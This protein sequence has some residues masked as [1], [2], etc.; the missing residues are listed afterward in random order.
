MCAKPVNKIQ[1]WEPAVGRLST[2]LTA[3]GAKMLASFLFLSSLHSPKISALYLEYLVRYGCFMN[4]F[5]LSCHF[6][7]KL[8]FFDLLQPYKFSASF[9]Y[10][11]SHLVTCVTV[12]TAVLEHV[13]VCCHIWAHVLVRNSIW[14]FGSIHSLQLYCSTAFNSLT[15]STSSQSE[16]IIVVVGQE[17]HFK[18]KTC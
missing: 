13:Q 11:Q 3:K 15:A 7:G 4:R 6:S 12:T 9:H 10:V 18:F 1:G 2:I 8:S 17:I 16:W 14:H 5:Y